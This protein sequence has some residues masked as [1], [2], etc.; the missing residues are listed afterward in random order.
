MNSLMVEKIGHT[1]GTPVDWLI[2]DF[3][4][5]DDISY[6]YIT[7]DLQSSFVTHKKAKN[8]DPIV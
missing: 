6:L 5:Q 4:K 2:A 8:D 7:H 3:S 1:R